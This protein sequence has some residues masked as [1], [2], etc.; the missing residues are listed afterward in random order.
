MESIRLLNTASVAG[1]TADGKEIDLIDLFSV[2]IQYKWVIF[3]CTLSA[4]VASIVFCI[5]SIEMPLDKSPL[6]N[7][8]TP[9][10][11]MLINNT[12]LADNQLL[13]IFKSGDLGNSSGEAS[14]SDLAI[15]LA[16][17]NS[18]LDAIAEKF[19]LAGRYAITKFSRTTARHILEK[20]MKASFD[21]S[22]GVFTI[23]CTDIDPYFAQ[24]VVNFA[25]DYMEQRFLDMGLDQTRLEKKNLE[26]NIHTAY[27]SIVGLQKK[28]RALELSASGADSTGH[29]PSIIFD[30]SMLKL[31][32]Q[33][34]EDLYAQLKTQYELIKVKMASE[35]P[36]FQ[37]IERAELPERK[38]G[39]A[40]GK[41]CLITVFVVLCISI[42][43]VWVV[44][45]IETI[46]QNSDA[47]DRLFKKEK[48]RNEKKF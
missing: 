31:E 3:L 29:V 6:P 12:A 24:S 11:H 15:Y 28:I 4:A 10:A 8:Y 38:S 37:I 43:I 21:K 46:R 20:K 17:T 26:D 44:D 16:G 39:P 48:K 5:V 2:I 13:Q 36:V 35:T 32:L 1:K 14:Y 25:V 34:Q 30:S 18:F 7:V 45:M 27:A 23:S 42:I 47:M 22:A 40:R 9:Q 19:D 41:L 33:S